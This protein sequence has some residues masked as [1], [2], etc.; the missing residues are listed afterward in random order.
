MAKDNWYL[1]QQ[2]RGVPDYIDEDHQHL[3]PAA[4]HGV[5]QPDYIP[6]PTIVED[7][8]DPK[9]TPGEEKYGIGWR[10]GDPIPK[11]KKA[12]ATLDPR[13]G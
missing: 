1:T 11:T 5:F 13:N 7:P 4:G 8:D 2:V 12:Q 6:D 3:F 10:E 9:I